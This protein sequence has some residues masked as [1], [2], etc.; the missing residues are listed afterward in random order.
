M[1]NHVKMLAAAVTLL[2]VAAAPVWAQ[3]PQTPPPA[4]TPGVQAPPPAAAPPASTP[5]AGTV[6]GTVKRVDPVARTINVSSGWLGFLF[7]KT[8]EVGPDTQVTVAGKDSSLAAIQEGAKV[9]ASYESR[10][11]KMIATR[12]EVLAEQDLGRTRS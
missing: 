2:A 8:L 12:I 9:K 5:T 4:P 1:S 7:G 11:G 10:D 6:E 3:T